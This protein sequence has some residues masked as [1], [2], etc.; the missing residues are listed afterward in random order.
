MSAEAEAK[1][2]LRRDALLRRKAAH[3]AR[4]EDWCGML[5]GV[6]SAHRGRPLAGYMAIRSEIDP[7]PA[8]VGAAAYGPVCVPV[9][10][11]PEQPLRFRAWHPDAAMIPGTFGAHTPQDGDWLEPEVLIVPLVAFDRLGGRLGYG[12]GFYDRTLQ[13]L[14]RRGPVVAIGF[15]YAAQE[16][17]ALPQEATDEPL[18]LVVTEAGV[19]DLPG[20]D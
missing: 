18:D 4:P 12:G 10:D 14:R 17:A 2:V 3:A 19:V 6:L 5:R 13:A 16:V 8:M 11:G 15:A 9:I 1:A 20:R 7:R